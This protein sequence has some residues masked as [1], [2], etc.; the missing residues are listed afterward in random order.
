MEC[1]K[2][3]RNEMLFAKKIFHWMRTL[4]IRFLVTTRNGPNLD[5]LTICIMLYIIQET[6]TLYSA[7]YELQ[8][9]YREC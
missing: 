3:Y 5:V 9:H 8:P 7:S 2:Q 4:H 1:E 6:V